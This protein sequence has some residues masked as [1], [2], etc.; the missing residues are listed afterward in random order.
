MAWMVLP[1]AAM[2]PATSSI[3]VLRPRPTV[4]VAALVALLACL[5]MA[6]LV[7]AGP[8]AAKITAR[9]KTETASLGQVKATFFY[10][11]K[12]P[13]T[14]TDLTLSIERNGALLLKAAKPF[15]DFWPGGFF[16]EPS[17]KV[18]DFEGNGE[19]EVLLN[20]YSGGAHCCTSAYVY[21]YQAATNSYKPVIRDFGDVGFKLKNLDRTGPLEFLSADPA[22][23]GAFTSYAESR[24]PVQ[25]LSFANGRF[26]DVTASF[27]ALVRRDL[28]A[29]KSAYSRFRKHHYNARG[30]LAAVA[31]DQYRLGAKAAGDATLARGKSLYGARYVKD[32]RKL[33]K[34][35]GYIG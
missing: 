21:R 13:V 14:Y 17:L 18:L 8:A 25:A 20:L 11:K 10:R 4:S 27:P 9:T 3:R 1:C 6:G 28:K 16:D 33:L 23:S 12:S 29:Q 35:G 24:F 19:P 30:A 2:T 5:L 32:V 31:A 22:F 15:K 34:R 26:T 7:G